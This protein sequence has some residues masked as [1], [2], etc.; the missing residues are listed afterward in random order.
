MTNSSWTQTHMQSLLGSAR[1]S[2][3]ASML[4]KDTTSLEKRGEE[5]AKCEVVYPPCDTKVLVGLGKLEGRK[6]EIVSLAQFRYLPQLIW[7]QY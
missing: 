3:L 7:N 1:S 4:L 6:R 5:K 2:L